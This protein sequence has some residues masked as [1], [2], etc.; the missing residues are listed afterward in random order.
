MMKTADV[1]ESNHLSAVGRCDLARF[2]RLLVQREMRSRSVIIG[3]VGSE[4]SFEVTLVQDDDVIEALPSESVDIA[5]PRG[6]PT[7]YRE[8]SHTDLAEV[9]PDPSSGWLG[10]AR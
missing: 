10:E 4:E 2:R 7:H 9:V 5:R 3:K 8:R 6:H 1:R